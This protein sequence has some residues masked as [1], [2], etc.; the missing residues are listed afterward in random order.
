[1][2]SNLK[3]V[4]LMI[5]W[6]AL[7]AAVVFLPVF[8]IGLEFELLV[9]GKFGDVNLVR[10]LSDELFMYFVLVVPLILMSLLYSL[11]SLILPSR[12]ITKRPR[13]VSIALALTVMGIFVVAN[14]GINDLLL[15]YFVP[16]L[17]ATLA[18]GLCT[19]IIRS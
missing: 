13:F 6:N 18:Y 12:W 7:M 4:A 17:L 11:L 5:L 3:K 15:G 14:S 9:R 1:M 16:T 2:I 19:T 10:V 8:L